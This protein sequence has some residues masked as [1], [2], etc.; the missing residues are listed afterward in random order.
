V[1]ERWPV[2]AF[3]VGFST[4][5][6][7][8]TAARLGFP[9]RAPAGAARAPRQLRGALPR[10]RGHRER[11]RR[12]TGHVDYFLPLRD[13]DLAAEAVAVLRPERLER[14]IGVIYRPETERWSHY[15][16]A[17]LPRQFDA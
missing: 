15:D 11:P 9:G 12:S 6:G 10:R 14:Y 13:G 7:T 16:A 5:A 17:A 8:V 4:Y 3:L 1:R 2:E